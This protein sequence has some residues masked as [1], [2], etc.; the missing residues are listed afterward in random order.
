MKLDVVSDEKPWFADGLTFTCTQCGDCCT[1]GPGYVWISDEEIE[2]LADFL[3]TSTQE[4]L[5]K[6]CRRLGDKISLKERR[7]PN[8]NYDCVFLTESP[9]PARANPRTLKEGQKLPQ[10][11][12]GCSIYPVRPLQC[13]TW[14]FWDS[15]IAD[16]DAW[17]ITAQRCPGMNRGSRTFTREQIET[18]RDAKDWPEN[19][20]TSGTK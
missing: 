16:K 17:E 3:K 10:K 6:Y 14:P 18:L 1:G 12:R 8:G 5:A 7:M 11:R 4:V 19:P 9:A 20:P 2:R 15:V 13:R